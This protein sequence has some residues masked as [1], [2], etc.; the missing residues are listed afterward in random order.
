MILCNK[1]LNPIPFNS[2]KIFFAGCDLTIISIALDNQGTD[3]I[4]IVS[5]YKF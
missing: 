1:N 4:A 2:G 5:F 3:R